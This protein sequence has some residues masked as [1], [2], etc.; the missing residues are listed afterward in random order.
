MFYMRA[1]I[2]M[3]VCMYESKSTFILADVYVIKYMTWMRLE[4][5]VNS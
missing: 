4:L 2:C 5:L 3:Y 1:L